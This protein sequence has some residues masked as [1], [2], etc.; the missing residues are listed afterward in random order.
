MRSPS[1]NHPILL[2]SKSGLTAI[3][4][5]NFN[6]DDHPEFEWA[7]KLLSDTRSDLKKLTALG[8]KEGLAWRTFQQ[9]GGWLGICEQGD[10]VSITEVLTENE[11]I[12]LAKSNLGGS[13][14]RWFP[15]IGINASSNHTDKHL[16][17]LLHELTHN[18][19]DTVHPFWDTPAFKFAL[20]CERA[21]GSETVLNLDDCMQRLIQR[22]HYS[23]AENNEE[24]VARLHERKIANPEKFAQDA[25]FI[26]TFFEQMMYPAIRYYVDGDQKAKEQIT[27]AM[28]LGNFESDS[29]FA[30]IYQKIKKAK[31]T[32]QHLVK[33]CKKAKGTPNEAVA[34]GRLKIHDL[35]DS[36]DIISTA[37]K[38][39]N[40]HADDA[41]RQATDRHQSFSNRISETLFNIQEIENNAATRNPPANKRAY[42]RLTT[43]E[44]ARIRSQIMQIK[45]P[46]FVLQAWRK[47]RE[48][49]Q[50][51]YGQT[52]YHAL[53]NGRNINRNKKNDNNR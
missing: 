40:A 39:F 28:R 50:H 46:D 21:R 19:N 47:G 43:L 6:I 29:P 36:A 1:E 30:D 53:L 15:I 4:D 18:L 20:D 45:S 52:N 32:R 26:N 12:T 22:G 51:N 3:A 8:P 14:H 33:E 17:T 41:N 16:T 27:D 7:K 42:P 25:P 37:R 48:L 38:L 11:K 35:M 31:E 49:V 5:K 34:T 9:Q 24:L 10:T 13:S 2:V 44:K 23:P